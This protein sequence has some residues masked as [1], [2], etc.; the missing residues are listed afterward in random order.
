MNQTNTSWFIFFCEKG[1][2][3]PKGFEIGLI[4]YCPVSAFGLQMATNLRWLQ[5]H[6]SCLNY[7]TW[8]KLLIWSNIVSVCVA[9][10]LVS[11]LVTLWSLYVR[12]WQSKLAN[13]RAN[14]EK[15]VLSCSLS[16]QPKTNL[17]AGPLT[18]AV[19]VHWV[20]VGTDAGCFLCRQ[21]FLPLV[22]VFFFS[23]WGLTSHHIG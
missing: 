20:S 13:D 3:F 19:V 15:A 22:H 23:E 5:A 12:S 4:I 17:A 18:T 11:L 8:C 9:W 6:N 7:R 2:K 21:G 10:Q 14:M 1:T 16:I